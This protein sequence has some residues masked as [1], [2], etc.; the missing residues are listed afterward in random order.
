MSVRAR[1]RGGGGPPEI[2]FSAEKDWMDYLQMRKLIQAESRR[3]LLGNRLVLVAPG[4]SK[5]SLKI[6]PQFEFAAALGKGRLATGDPDSVPAGRYARAALTTLGVWSS[7]ADRIV[8]AE[9]VRAAL[10]FVER[11]EAPLGIVYRT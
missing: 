2:F 10:A 11:G 5:L 3:D 9:N 6:E 7:V 4:A 1:K 8:G